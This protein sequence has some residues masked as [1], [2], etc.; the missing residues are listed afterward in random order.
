MKEQDVETERSY[1]NDGIF[2]IQNGVAVTRSVK[3]RRTFRCLR[4]KMSLVRIQW[5]FRLMGE[6]HTYIV[7]E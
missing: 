2:W 3:D 5:P 1:V 6:M 4:F 7:I